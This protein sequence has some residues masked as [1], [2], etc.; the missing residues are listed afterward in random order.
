MPVNGLTRE[1]NLPATATLQERFDAGATVRPSD[2]CWPW[3]RTTNNMG[4]GMVSC[5]RQKKML[6]HRAAYELFVGPVPAGLVVHHH[7]KNPLCCNP[8]HL[9][10]VTRSEHAALDAWPQ[11]QPQELCRQGHPISTMPS[12]R[13]RCR[14]CFRQYSRDY[15]RRT[16][17]GWTE[18]EIARGSRCQ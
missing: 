1:A 12:G 10:A 9:Q 4:Y 17:L 7:C 16:R 3:Q 15:A 6:A 5:G 8:A 11:C 14:E 18:D 2:G 13:R